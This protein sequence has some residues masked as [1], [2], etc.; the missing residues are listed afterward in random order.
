MSENKNSLDKAALFLA[1]QQMKQ[2]EAEKKIANQVPEKTGYDIMQEHTVTNPELKEIAKKPMQDNSIKSM[3][4]P[5]I[6]ES[7]HESIATNQSQ[8]VNEQQAL[9]AATKAT[10][11]QPA[12]PVK[13][14]KP[15]TPVQESP[16]VYTK[17][18]DIVSNNEPVV[19]NNINHDELA[20]IADEQLRDKNRIS[21]RPVVRDT[22]VGRPVSDKTKALQNA[23][24]VSEDFALSFFD[25]DKKSTIK[26][27]PK[28]MLYF[29][30]AELRAAGLHDIKQTDMVVGWMASKLD[31]IALKKLAV[32]LND[33]QLRVVK[34][35]H[36]NA[37]D[38]D[39]ERL[40]RIENQLQNLD[41]KMDSVRLLDAYTFMDRAGWIKSNDASLSPSRISFDYTGPIGG[42]VDVIKRADDSVLKLRMDLNR[43]AGRPKE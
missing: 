9:D 38:S 22:N 11:S 10:Q 7:S 40:N 17:A 34:A 5:A 23:S 14:T 6:N 15:V 43:K 27:F 8:V 1:Q 21:K 4:A 36:H 28:A 26:D 30:E 41:K 13:E 12:Q 35:L 18:E 16:R 20:N 19:N 29:I 32:A 37:I 31:A 42:I 24:R 25:A 2:A 39:T 33:N 3:V